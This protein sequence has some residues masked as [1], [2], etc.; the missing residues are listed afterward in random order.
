MKLEISLGRSRE[1]CDGSLL[2]KII[3]CESI[4]WTRIHEADNLQKK[5]RGR[6]SCQEAIALGWAWSNQG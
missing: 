2:T 5:E 1:I 4:A 6:E 3:W